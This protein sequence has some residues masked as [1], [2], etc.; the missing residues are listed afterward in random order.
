MSS[1]GN[2]YSSLS[3][4]L[5]QINNKTLIIAQKNI[6]WIL[7]LTID[8]FNQV[9]HQSVLESLQGRED[10]SIGDPTL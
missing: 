8:N 9:S 4:Y 3:F 6:F 2:L 10:V 7:N 1:R 5:Q